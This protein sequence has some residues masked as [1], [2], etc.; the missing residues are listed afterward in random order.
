MISVFKAYLQG[1]K[2]VWIEKKLI[3]LIYGI[4]VIFAYLLIL[5]ISTMLNKSFSTS[6][7]AQQIL[8]QFDLT[9]FAVFFRNYFRDIDIFRLLLTYGFL[10]LLIS[11]FLAGGIVWL[12]VTKSKFSIG[13]FFNRCVEYFS[14]F[15]RL[16]FVSIL[17][18]IAAIVV[19]VLIGN[20]FDLIS[21]DSDN[22]VLIFSL[23]V[24]RICI[25]LIL[26]AIINMIFDYAKIIT[27]AEDRHKMIYAPPEAIKFIMMNLVQTFGLFG[28]YALTGMVLLVLYLV[29]EFTFIVQS[30]VGILVFVILSQ[31][32]VLLRQW[33]R[34]SFFSG[35]TIYYQHTMTAMPGMLTK[36]MMDMAVDNYEK[37]VKKKDKAKA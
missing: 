4:Q 24:V 8:Q 27:V 22:E 31:I 6:T 16:F 5:P 21:G 19:F 29:L 15:F 11:I 14:R 3:F 35:Q 37:Q 17:Y 10:Y 30:A 28:L 1:I 18:M 12:F 25:L 32:Y 9:V 26:L 2:E 36:E 23:L 20:L 13:E 7:K 33:L 34:L